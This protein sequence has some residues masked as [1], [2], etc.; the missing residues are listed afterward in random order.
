[1]D[2]EKKINKEEN[3]KKEKETEDE[4]KH[5]AEKTSVNKKEV[6]KLIIVFAVCCIVVLLTLKVV[7]APNSDNGIGFISY[8]TESDESTVNT[9][10][11]ILS[12]ETDKTEETSDEFLS[13]ETEGET[14]TEE[15]TENIQNVQPE[16]FT[17]LLEKS[18]VNID[19]LNCGQLVIVESSG[20]SAEVSFYEKDEDG[21]WCDKNLTVSGWVGSNGVDDKSQEGDYKTP[22]GLY[23][24]GEAFYIYDQPATGLDSFQVT[25]NTYWV[26]DP[27]SQY[28]NQRVEGTENMDWNSAEHMLSYSISY[29][30]GFVVNFN[31]DP[32]VPGKGSAIFF[33]CGSGPTAGCIAVPESSVLSYL[34]QLDK[35]KSPCILMI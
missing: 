14:E 6:I 34:E 24:I 17:R 33:H 27:N 8:V 20:N 4:K 25:E 30:Y 35:S 28:Y 5:S 26:D 16:E 32:I 31:M 10:E 11:Q 18:G 12:E 21:L 22:F 19:Q 7:F 29:K 23:S 3:P 9:T 1:M 13:E 2:E 15:E